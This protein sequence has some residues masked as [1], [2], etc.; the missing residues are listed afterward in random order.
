MIE[1]TNLQEFLDGLTLEIDSVNLEV[2]E[3]FRGFCVLAFHKV[4]MNTPQWSG[5][6]ASNWNF[7]VGSEDT[8]VDYTFKLEDAA[9]NKHGAFYGYSDYSLQSPHPNA[10]PTAFVKNL[11]KE[12]AVALD[13]EVYICNSAESLDH[14]SY[15]MFLEDNPNNFLRPENNPGHMVEYAIN[16][17]SGPEFTEAQLKILRDVKI[18]QLTEGLLV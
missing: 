18:G 13:S 10:T 16:E 6:A 15:I 12:N 4:V 7:S 11:G 8:S 2:T 17:L 1:F 5:S 3:A 14:Q 9:K